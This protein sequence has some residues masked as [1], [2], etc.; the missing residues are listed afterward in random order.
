MT[1]ACYRLCKYPVDIPRIL[2]ISSGQR[3][4]RLGQ[5]VYHASADRGSITKL[6]LA[7]SH[8]CI[9]RFVFQGFLRFLLHASFLHFLPLNFSNSQLCLM[10]H[11]KC[12][13]VELAKLRIVFLILLQQKLQNTHVSPLLSA[14]RLP[15]LTHLTW[16][17]LQF[18]FLKRFLLLLQLQ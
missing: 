7:V 14:S 12:A 3:H 6:R 5:Q 17:H 2:H 16:R 10:I 9:F 11:L 13:R 1:A 8:R 18:L 4:Y 15:F